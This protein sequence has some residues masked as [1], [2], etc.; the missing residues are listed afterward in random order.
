MSASTASSLV[1]VNVYPEHRAHVAS[2]VW[3]P[4]RIAF[5]DSWDID[6]HLREPAVADV[7]YL[8]SLNS[9][10]RSE[11]DDVI[12]EIR[13][14]RPLTPIIAY[15]TI[16]DDWA[17]QAIGAIQAGADHLALHEFDDLR[18]MMAHVGADA[19]LLSACANT[20]RLVL[21]WV[22][23]PAHSVVGLCTMRA[24]RTLSVNDL[25]HTIGTSK[26]SLHRQLHALRLPT[27]ESTISWCR[28]FVAVYL[29]ANKREAVDH[30]AGA[31]GFRSGAGLRNMLRR[32]TGRTAT[33]TR[34]PE[35]VSRLAQLYREA[36]R[37]A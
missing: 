17:G 31:L 25:A 4:A 3:P 6:R 10:H 9:T 15:A 33:A 5:L 23:E 21:P 16:L 20:L 35:A 19:H 37:S 8:V 1:A 13:L 14:A 18:R 32:Y 24:P 29:I 11:I 7:S 2:A 22:P 34:D 26:R 28:L 27:P 36:G 12:R 30:V